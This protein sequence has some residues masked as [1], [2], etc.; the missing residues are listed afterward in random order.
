MFNPMNLLHGLGGVKD[1]T[2]ELTARVGEG[3]KVAGNRVK[4][5]GCD[6]VNQ[7]RDK[8]AAMGY[9]SGFTIGA[10]IT[11]FGVALATFPSSIFLALFYLLLAMICIYAGF[12]AFAYTMLNALGSQLNRITVAA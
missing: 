10:G 7:C 9:C 3:A 8:H 12:T 6:I 4:D 11:L 2:L 5:I 1:A